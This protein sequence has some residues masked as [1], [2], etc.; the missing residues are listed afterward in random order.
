MS[1]CGPAEEV[2]EG[3]E[4]HGADWQG[5]KE[6]YQLELTPSMGAIRPWGHHAIRMKDAFWP[7][8]AHGRAFCDDPNAY[9][10][11]V[12]KGRGVPNHDV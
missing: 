2:D 11:R 10:G 9:L 4:R 8:M 5:I 6:P 3:V 1:A 7:W 12:L